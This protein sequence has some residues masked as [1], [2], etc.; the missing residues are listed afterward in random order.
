MSPGSR[1][2]LSDASTLLSSRRGAIGALLIVLVLVHQ[3]PFFAPYQPHTDDYTYNLHLIQQWLHPGSFQGNLLSQH[4]WAEHTTLAPVYYFGMVFPLSELL[5]SQSVMPLVGLV[6]GVLLVLA[7]GQRWTKSEDYVRAVLV[8]LVLLHVPYG[9]LEAH[10]RSFVPVALAVFFWINRCEAPRRHGVLLAVTAGI[11]PPAALLLLAGL[12]LDVLTRA[13][14]LRGAVRR[15]RRTL[16]PLSL[17]V[18]LV[19]SPYLVNRLG[20]GTADPSRWASDLSYALNGPLAVFRTFV[21]PDSGALFST[22]GGFG[23]CLVGGALVLLERFVLGRD[24]F[25]LRRDYGL[26][27]LGAL[28]LWALAHLVHP[29]LYHPVKYTRSTLLIV[30]WMIAAE[31]FPALVRTLRNRWG[32]TVPTVTSAGIAAAAAGGW[33]FLRLTPE[34][35]RA[36]LVVLSPGTAWTGGLLFLPLLAG[37]SLLPAIN[38]PARDLR[39]LLLAFGLGL[40]LFFPHCPVQCDRYGE[41]NHPIRHYR[42]LFE[43]LRATPAGST[44]AGPPDLMD[45]IPGYG[46]R[47]VHL[48]HELK[49]LPEVCRRMQS[50]ARTYYAGSHEHVVRYLTRRNIDYL[51]VEVDAFESDPIPDCGANVPVNPDAVLNRTH[52]DPTWAIPGEYYLLS[53]DELVRALTGSR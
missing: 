13:D 33:A 9:P 35:F 24:R 29:L 16:V 17:V 14:G 40:F 42:G 12:G 8:T 23:V 50:F 10:R 1:R 48:M 46:A 15:T 38:R 7:A 43:S 26:M 28:G 20:P 25:R 22:L 41:D 53:T 30:G 4:V 44:V 45:P 47:P 49:R 19:L 21:A 52:P 31:N 51:L 37:V 2:F 6:F 11:Y 18:L 32:G 39:C 3:L 5:P 27:V 34:A 36:D